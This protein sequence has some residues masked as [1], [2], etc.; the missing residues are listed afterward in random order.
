MSS[1]VPIEGAQEV[2]GAVQDFQEPELEIDEEDELRKQ[3]DMDDF[4]YDENHGENT[5]PKDFDGWAW[6]LSDSDDEV[7]HDVC[8]K[9]NVDVKAD[10]GAAAASSGVQR[11]RVAE[12]REEYVNHSWSSSR[13]TRMAS[14]IPRFQTLW[15]D[16]GNEQDSKESTSGGYQTYFGRLHRF[17]Q[18]GQDCQG[19]AG[20]S[21]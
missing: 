5:I 14:L 8:E 21:Y 20:Q 11:V 2:E 1:H 4:E 18:N 16:M 15:E 6:A 13:S 9:S 12:T 10:S 7:D 19:P 3:Y 17:E